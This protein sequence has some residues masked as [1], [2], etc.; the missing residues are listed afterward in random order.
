MSFGYQVLGFGSGGA[1]NP[2]MV[3]TGGNT[4]TTSGND[5]IHTFTGPG[6]FTVCTAAVCA[7][8]NLVSYMVVAGGGGTGTNIAGG[9]GGG[10]FRELVSPTAPYTASPLQGYPTPGNRIT[11]SATGYPITVGAGGVGAPNSCQP[12][13]TSGA[14]SVFSSITSAGG[15]KGGCATVPTPHGNGVAGGSGGGEA[16]GSEVT[17]GAGNTPPTTPAQGNPGGPGS[18]GGQFPYLGAGGGGGAIASGGP[19]TSSQ[20]GIGGAGAGTLIN[21]ATG[22]PGPGP[23]QY[24]AGGAGGGLYCGST[25]GAAG[26]GGA[27]VA[28]PGADPTRSGTANTGGGA[29]GYGSGGSGIVIIRYK[30]Q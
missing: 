2:Y 30:Y 18:G 24:Y 19:G 22:Q 27:G 4:I 16:G 29:A 26:I 11:V 5:K 20:T 23:S 8:N 28:G 10:G 25:W 9:G 7:T 15:G 14:N 17:Y 21:P 6:T 3:A 12:S 1:G 13:Q